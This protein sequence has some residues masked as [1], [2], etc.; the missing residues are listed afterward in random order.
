MN[1]K[2]IEVPF[3]DLDWQHRPLTTELETAIQ[4]VVKAG[5]FILGQSLADFERD[6]ATSCGAV[7]GVGVAS[8]TDAI[9]LGLR[10]CGI[11]AGDEVLV[12][13]NTFIAS[14]IGVLQAGAIPVFVDCDSQTAL[15]DLE[16]AA[17]AVTQKTR[18]IVPVHLYG[19]MVSP[20]QL[21]DFAAS[22]N[23]T[24]FEDAAQAHL[25]ARE[26]YRA[27][28]VGRAAA[29]S[30]YPSKNLGAF[31][32]GAWLS[33]TTKK[34]RSQSAAFVIMALPA[35]TTTWNWELTA[36]STPCKRQFSR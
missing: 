22:Y 24:I 34:W 6:F 9:A 7:W 31:G 15:I 13:A 10:A 19:Q 18:A 25:A 17:K 23:L 12:P 27:G 20:K 4:S 33:P 35:N 29:F 3:V 5:D 32:N 2:P 1:P 14:A 26:G 21:L 8:G 30:F 11:G 16:R 36:A 28:S